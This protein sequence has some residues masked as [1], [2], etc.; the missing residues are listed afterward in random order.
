MVRCID[1]NIIIEPS[2]VM[3]NA[4]EKILDEKQISLTINIFFFGAFLSLYRSGGF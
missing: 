4:Y 3:K 1:K 2:I